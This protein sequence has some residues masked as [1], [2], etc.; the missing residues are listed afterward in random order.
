ML[1]IKLFFVAAILFVGFNTFGQTKI[2]AKEA[3]KHLNE[4]VMV[5]DQIFGGKYLDHSNITLIDVGGNHPHELLTLVIRGND[6]KKF[7]TAPEVTF[8]GK[9]V[10]VTGKVVDY[11]VK[12][13]IIITDPD[14]IKEDK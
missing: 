14:Q 12:P 9:S 8:R 13:E 6:R 1:K 3:S 11:K 5:C 4:R 2:K 7:K 10:C